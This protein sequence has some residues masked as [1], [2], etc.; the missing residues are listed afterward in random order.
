MSPTVAMASSAWLSVDS[1]GQAHGASCRSNHSPHHCGTVPATLQGHLDP[2]RAVAKTGCG[3]LGT[4]LLS[5]EELRRPTGKSGDRG[6]LRG[7]PH[8]C[9]LT[10]QGGSASLG[11]PATS[12]GSSGGSAVKSPP[13]M[14][15][16]Q[17]TCV[18]STGGEDSLEEGMA[19]HCS[20]LA[21]RITRT[22]EPGGYSPG[23][24]KDLDTTE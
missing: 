10:Q 22:E 2:E 9:V 20:I 4:L 3:P 1:L 23:G 21:W 5:P 7:P 19:T 15:E 12:V 11:C 14:K 17:E 18:R 6:N 8:T 16:P 13:A 24:H